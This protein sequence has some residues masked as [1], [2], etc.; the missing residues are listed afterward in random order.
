MQDTIGHGF[1]LLLTS[2]T[3]EITMF[4]IVVTSKYFFSFLE[5]RGNHRLLTFDP[6]CRTFV[7][8]GCTVENIFFDRLITD[9]MALLSDHIVNPSITIPRTALSSGS[10]PE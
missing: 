7:G 10:G 9:S 6:L 2:I 4:G 3:V 5:L 1:V 8:I